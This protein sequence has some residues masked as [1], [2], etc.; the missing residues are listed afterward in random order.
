M[1][2]ELE[3]SLK[4][5]I[6][7]TETT[8][9]CSACKFSKEEHRPDGTKWIIGC[10]V[11][12]ELGLMPIRETGV[13]KLFKVKTPRACQ[14]D[15]YEIMSSTLSTLIAEHEGE[16]I[17]EELFADIMASECRKFGIKLIKVD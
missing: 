17:S 2:K 3:K 4:D 1:E 16:Y 13:C 7:Y 8:K 10:S 14:K 5:E 9:K 11:F 12:R 15:R 6:E